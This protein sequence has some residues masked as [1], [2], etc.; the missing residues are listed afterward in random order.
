MAKYYNLLVVSGNK[1]LSTVA[2]SREHA[3]ADFGEKIGKRLTLAEP[4]DSPVPDYMLDEWDDSPHW[5]N[6]HIPVFEV[7]DD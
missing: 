6:P 3:L 4:P 2:G 5:V 7:S 1:I